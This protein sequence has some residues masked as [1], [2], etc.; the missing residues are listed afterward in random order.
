MAEDAVLPERRLEQHALAVPVLGDEARG[1]PRGG[2]ACSSAVMSVGAASHAA[3]VPDGERP[4][5]HDGVD[6]LGL[7][8]ALDAGDADDL[9]LADGQADVVDSGAPVRG[10]P[11]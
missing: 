7:A 10:V 11:R 2:P 3:R 8:V 4:Q 1:R 6:E 5:A 9:A